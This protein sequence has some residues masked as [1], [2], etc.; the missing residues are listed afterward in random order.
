MFETVQK[1][2]GSQAQK[3]RDLVAGAFETV[4]KLQ[5]SQAWRSQ[6]AFHHSLRLYRNYKVLKLATW[7]SRQTKCLR[8]YRNYKVL[9]PVI[10]RVG[11]IGV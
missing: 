6:R 8:L 2:Q 10:G 7:A 3:R 4:Q 1:L 11:F 9:K 5:G